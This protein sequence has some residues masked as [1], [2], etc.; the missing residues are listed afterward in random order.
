MRASRGF[1]VAAAHRV[2][3]R[4][5]RA[6]M[7][8]TRR[9]AYFQRSIVWAAGAFVLAG[10]VLPGVAFAEAPPDRAVT[11][12]KR[13]FAQGSALYLK[14]RYLEALEALERSYTLAPS[15]NS[16]LVSARCL[17]E[18]GR[19][20]EAQDAFASA[21]IEARR[22]AAEGAPK[23]AQTADSAAT[24]GAAVRSGLGAVR[25]RIDAAPPGTTLFVD[26][27]P[28]EIPGDGPLV[29][30]HPP[31]D[32]GVAVRSAAGIEQKQVSTV[33]A[34]TETTMVFAPTPAPP[35]EPPPTAPAPRAAPTPAAPAGLSEAVSSPGPYAPSWAKPAAYGAGALTVVGAAL[36]TGFYV[37][38]QN[39][40]NGLAKHCQFA[41]GGLCTTADV[42][43]QSQRT[44]GKTEQT[45]AYI[46]LAA[47]AVSAV[48]AVTFAVVA[49]SHPARPPGVQ[50][51]RWRPWV[52]GATAGRG[53]LGTPLLG[54][55]ADF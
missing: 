36:F 22:R 45:V 12:A 24:E 39:R 10:I 43:A 54:I 48:A 35:L 32:V 37:A 1:V 41:A 13:L 30:W 2:D 49:W 44:S 33:R 29:F 7:R 4:I 31:G 42:Y 18:L 50:S 3:V 21:E 40:F 19:L 52:D 47:G 16:Q 23:Y 11:D 28:T 14:G 38:T 9:V 51:D 46:S 26:G 34:G 25:V 27:V 5:A 15:P 17:R 8:T 55:A 53:A 20:V 6:W